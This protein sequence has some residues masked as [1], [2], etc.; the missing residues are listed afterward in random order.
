MATISRTWMG[1]VQKHRLVLVALRA[2]TCHNYNSSYSSSE[3]ESL[4]SVTKGRLGL[5]RGDV[6][7]GQG[8]GGRVTFLATNQTRIRDEKESGGGGMDE[9]LQL[10]CAAVQVGADA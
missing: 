8:G 10:G 4:M 7:E 6:E 1:G 3:S 5:A 9:A 2:L